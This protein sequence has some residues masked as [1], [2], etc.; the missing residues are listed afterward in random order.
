MPGRCGIDEGHARRSGSVFS[1]RSPERPRVSRVD[2]RVPS[3]GLGIQQDSDCPLPEMK[4]PAG[5]ETD[6]WDP[7]LCSHRLVD[8]A[9]G[10]THG[11]GDRQADRAPR[12]VLRPR[13]SSPSGFPKFVQGAWSGK[14]SRRRAR[15]RHWRLAAGLGARARGKLGCSIAGPPALWL[16]RGATTVRQDRLGEREDALDRIGFP[17]ERDCPG[18]EPRNHRSG[19]RPRQTL[20]SSTPLTNGVGPGIDAGEAMR[21]DCSAP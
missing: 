3:P 14:G 10:R 20:V 11:N 18:V 2:S 19:D 16:E 17:D 12:P 7:P 4:P 21:A 8:A 1:G 9:L 5:D 6:G 15:A 13:M